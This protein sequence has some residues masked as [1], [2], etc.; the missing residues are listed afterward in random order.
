M[1]QFRPTPRPLT[2]LDKLRMETDLRAKL[3][4][5]AKCVNGLID[6]SCPFNYQQMLVLMSTS[7]ERERTIS[8]NSDAVLP[9]VGYL[10]KSRNY[11]GTLQATFAA[12]EKINNYTIEADRENKPID[13]TH[14]LDEVMNRQTGDNGLRIVDTSNDSASTSVWE[15]DEFEHVLQHPYERKRPPSDNYKLDKKKREQELQLQQKKKK[16]QQAA[17][18]DQSKTSEEDTSEEG[19]VFD[20]AR[21]PPNGP[22]DGE[23]SSEEDDANQE[24]SSEKKKEGQKKTKKKISVSGIE[25]KSMV[26]GPVFGFSHLQKSAEDE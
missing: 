5:D 19:L 15:D 4:S 22:G 10:I 1:T 11:T 7:L 14:I 6:H 21:P 2:A 25:I 20:R 18:D 24:Y 26:P 23:S 3:L 13:F 17:E 8:F 12:I 9:M 16:E